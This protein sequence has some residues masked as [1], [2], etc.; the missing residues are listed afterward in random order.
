MDVTIAHAVSSAPEWCT[1]QRMVRLLGHVL[2]TEPVAL[3]H[4]RAG[5]TA[6]MMHRSAPR[7][8]RSGK[9]LIAVLTSGTDLID[10]RMSAVFRSGFD[11]VAVWIV[12]SFRTDHISRW[13]SFAGIDV[14]AI[15]QD[16]DIPFYSARHGGKVL[17]LPYGADTLAQPDNS[18]C[19]EHDLVRFGRQPDTWANDADT[20]AHCRSLGLTFHGRPPF[21]ECPDENHENVQ[22]LL[23]S[24]KC[25]LAFSNL[26]STEA[27]TH[28][29]KPYF[30]TRWADA[31][32]C[33][34]AVAG[35]PP[36]GD[37]A[38][39]D[40]LW[41]GAL[42]NLET[43]ERAAGLTEITHF[44]SAWTPDTARTNQANAKLRLDWRLRFR[45]LFTALGVESP[46]LDAELEQLE[47]RAAALLGTAP[48]P[49]G[50]PHP[51]E[52]QTA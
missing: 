22:T 11:R 16:Y 42:V 51:P 7:A 13:D 34:A 19:R 28:P 48:T 5:R 36:L 47:R 31:L 45:T 14:L 8:R 21:S 2:Q 23:R 24:A 49:R 38:F 44:C 43:T 12:D 35:V 6:R 41:P 4:Q 40:L 27:Y 32:A 3:P 37:T 46:I 29:T 17:V 50:Q 18:D 1:I 9:V 20:D 10:L 25:A 15:A 30:S 33:G 26:S 39:G 52:Q